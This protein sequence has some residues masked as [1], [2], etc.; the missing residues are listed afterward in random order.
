MRNKTREVGG[1]R[2]LNLLGQIESN[3]ELQAVR[4]GTWT[5][6]QEYE[7][8]W[9]FPTS[10]TYKGW[11]SG[12][13]VT[14]QTGQKHSITYCR[15]EADHRWARIMGPGKSSVG[16]GWRNSGILG[17]QCPWLPASHRIEQKKWE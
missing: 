3:A 13:F 1:W 16:S 14:G 6:V 5:V 12:K 8:R 15:L 9:H 10:A 11:I 2:T 4:I 7:R 17:S